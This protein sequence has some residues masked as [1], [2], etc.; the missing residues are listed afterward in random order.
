M[1]MDIEYV[2]NKG[3]TSRD[4]TRSTSPSQER[5]RFRRAGHFLASGRS[6]ISRVTHRRRTTLFKRSSKSAVSSGLWFLGSYTF[7]KSL[8]T[9]NTPA[10]GGRYRLRKG[11]LRVSRP[12]YVCFQLWL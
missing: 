3:T 6:A 12:A 9:Q 1:V 10:A 11:A 8:W 4:K 7:S 2:G 5:A